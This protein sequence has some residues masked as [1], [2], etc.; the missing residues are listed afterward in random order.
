V[1]PVIASARPELAS[2]A[3]NEGY[4][5][6][7]AQEPWESTAPRALWVG[8]KLEVPWERV[9]AGFAFLEKWELAVPIW[10]WGTLAAAVGE[11]AERVLSE[12]LLLDLRVPLYDPRLLFLRGC[13]STL[14]LLLAYAQE[15]LLGR[16]RLL[17]FSRA[18]SRVKPIFCALPTSW[19]LD[20]PEPII[21]PVRRATGMVRIEVAPGKYAMCHPGNE[22]DTIRRW[23]QEHANQ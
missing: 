23:R 20:V 21:Q 17:A 15:S 22:E 8:N 7:L 9:P 18:L 3:E 2:E 19:L 16:N 12:K 10:R 14:E 11:E 4:E 13:Q 5:F 1:I 6:Q